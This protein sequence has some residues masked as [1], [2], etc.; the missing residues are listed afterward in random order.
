[1][2]D[3]RVFLVL[4]LWRNKEERPVWSETFLTKTKL[5]GFK[6]FGIIKRS[7][8]RDYADGNVK[9]AFENS[10]KFDPVSD[11]MGSKTYYWFSQLTQNTVLKL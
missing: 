8:S 11:T 5:S 4:T 1:M 3:I 6:V 2:S 7:K 10:R 9:L